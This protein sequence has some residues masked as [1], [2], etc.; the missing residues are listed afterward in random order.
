MVHL[1]QRRKKYKISG[2]AR[3]FD[4]CFPFFSYSK[5]TIGGTKNIAKSTQV[6][7][8]CL[9]H[10][11]LTSAGNPRTPKLLEAYERLRPQT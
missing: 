6:A 3:T 1:S 2:Q 5:Q 7:T 10:T 11:Q 4:D 9:K 8:T